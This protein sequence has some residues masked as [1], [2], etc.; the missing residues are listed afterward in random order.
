MT[1]S[2]IPFPFRSLPSGSFTTGGA[3]RVGKLLNGDPQFSGCIQDII[4][5]PDILVAE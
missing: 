4:L 2:E 1:R 5:Y 3:Y